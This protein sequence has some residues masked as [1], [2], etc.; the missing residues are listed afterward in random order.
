MTEAYSK[1]LE[2][3]QRRNI[4]LRD[5]SEYLALSYKGQFEALSQSLTQRNISLPDYLKYLDQTSQNSSSPKNSTPENDPEDLKKLEAVGQILL[6]EKQI[7]LKEL[8]HLLESL[9]IRD[10]ITFLQQLLILRKIKPDEFVKFLYGKFVFPSA[11]PYQLTP[12]ENSMKFSLEIKK[13]HGEYG[14]YV[15]LEE[16]GRGGMGVVYKAYHPP[17]NRMVALKVLLA[18]K[19]ASEKMQQRF[20]RE[21]EVMAK[22]EH[23]GIVKIYDSG[24]EGE[25]IYLAMEYVEGASLSKEMEQ[26]SLQEKVT[27]TQQV[28]K[29]L[30]YAHEHGIIHR[31]LKLDNIL[32]T[33]EKAP[34]IA[35]FGLAKIMTEEG[36]EKLTESGVL[37]GT[38]KY[39]APEQARGKVS[40]IEARSD[41]YAIGVCLYRLLT[42]HFPY[43]GKSLHQLLHRIIHKEATLPSK[44]VPNLRRDLEAIVLKALEKEKEKRYQTAEAFA[45]DLERFLK[46]HRVEA[47]ENEFQRQIRRWFKKHHLRVI[48]ALTGIGVLFLGMFLKIGLGYQERK[49]LYEKKYQA[50]LIESTK[51]GFYAK[52]QSW[53]YLNEALQVIPNEPVAERK[54]W[55]VGEA[56]LKEVLQ[57]ENRYVGDYVIEEMQQLSTL[58][59]TQRIQRKERWANE[60][61]AYWTKEEQ[62]FEYWIS[63][64]SSGEQV[65]S[66]EMNDALFEI[67]KMSAPIINPRLLEI[68]QKG[69]RFF[70][71]ENIAQKE[72]KAKYYQWAI[73]LLNRRKMKEALPLICESLSTLSAKY[74][75][76]KI[77]DDLEK[78]HSMVKMA[79]YLLAIQAYSKADFLL[80]KRYESGQNSLFWIRSAFILKKLY[81]LNLELTERSQS[82]PQNA[83]E[84]YQRGF[85][86]RLSGDFKGAIND[87][88]ETI[89]LNP[90]DAEAYNSRGL[91]KQE[92]K[93]LEGAINDYNEAIRLNPQFAEAYYNRGLAKQEKK[94]LEGAINDY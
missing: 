78:I 51:E 46:G 54:K 74:Q 35:D 18:G 40:E 76:F 2:N 31:D 21:I 83:Q 34:K 36:T 25:A 1:L 63:R 22:L 48:L 44:Y 57:Q 38:A 66:E 45:D 86:K 61:N 16:L 9:N 87:F 13:G 42:Q 32:I 3:L 15:L 88:S 82:V 39:M 79:R 70:E 55:D 17:L 47:L 28:L 20:R 29:A 50:F 6:Q 41:I 84:F 26:L 68:L 14:E 58:P 89:R 59:V 30:Y 60:K 72:K 67:L 77:P 8:N 69:N 33:P 5:Y 43:E 90:Q 71:Q 53:N 80:E 23:E 19:A 65:G 27:I 62:R 11:S 7:S 4:E 92:K 85:V 93:D 64:L 24:N 49:S 12:H 37:I 10:F 73:D 94:D 56:L 75:T 81:Q 91:A 52:L